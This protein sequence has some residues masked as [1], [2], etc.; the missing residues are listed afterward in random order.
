MLKE[1]ALRAGLNCGA[2]VNKNGESCKDKACCDRWTLHRFRRTF[3]TSRHRE[4]ASLLDLKKWLGH[5]DLKT[6][7]LY[8]AESDLESPEVRSCTNHSYA[9]YV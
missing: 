8:L 6:T 4:G 3:A 1:L 5:S 2:C 9:A 7:E